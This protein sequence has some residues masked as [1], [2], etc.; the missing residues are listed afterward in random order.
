ME[1]AAPETLPARMREC[2]RDLLRALAAR[3][4]FPRDT[5]SAAFS[6]SPESFQRLVSSQA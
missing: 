4:K 1:P 5:P 2:D 3:A 6:R